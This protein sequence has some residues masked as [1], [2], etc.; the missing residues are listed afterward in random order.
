MLTVSDIVSD[1]ALHLVTGSADSV[2]RPI[3]WVHVSEH[4]DP[5][6]WISGGELVLTTGYNLQD[7]AKQR[8][9]MRRLAEH[10]VTGI[11]FGVGFDHPE[12]PVAMVD[13]SHELDIPLIRVSYDL[14]FIEI[15]ERASERLMDERH[16]ALRRVQQIQLQLER[17]L[18]GGA[19]LDRIVG[20]LSVETQGSA[21]VIDHTGFPATA[22]GGHGIEPDEVGRELQA[23]AEAGRISPFSP[24]CLDGA[25]LAFPIPGSL[26]GTGTSWLVFGSRHGGAPG[27]FETLLVKACA[28]LCGLQRMKAAAVLLTERRI[29]K[30][31]IAGAIDGTTDP[32]ETAARLDSVGLDGDIAVLVFDAGDPAATLELLESLSV[33]R[34]LPAVA[35][36]VDAPSGRFVCLILGRHSLSAVAEASTLVEEVRKTD[37][38]S[39]VGVSEPH[40]GSQLRRAFHEARCSLQATSL[41]EDPPPVS[42]RSELGALSLLLAM[43]DDDALRAFSDSVLEPIGPADDPFAQE[44][45]LSLETFIDCNGN[46]ERASRSLYCHRHTLRHRINRIE[47]RTNRDLGSAADR[48]ECWLALKARHIVP[49]SLPGR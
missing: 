7:E 4:E 9:F 37:P 6:P 3:R 27:R 13:A 24:S 38:S 21:M 26:V 17:E 8:S 11:G 20:I 25:G 47:E 48:I 1:P 23:R 15:I 41:N 39:R 29:A 33:E 46:W 32:Q 14:P 35:S 45:L 30:T 31:L 16:E 44:L 28:T 49:P 42:T 36:C 40:P 10:E 18:I 5:G 2:S 22:N 19:G 43:N 12:V 34:S